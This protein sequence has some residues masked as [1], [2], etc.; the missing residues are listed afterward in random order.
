MA[1]SYSLV[2]A[3]WSYWVTECEEGLFIRGFQCAF[4]RHV[5]RMRKRRPGAIFEQHLS[6]VCMCGTASC[7]VCVS[8]VQQY[9]DTN[10][11]GVVYE[12]NSYMEQ[13]LDTGGDNKLLLYELCNIIKT[14]QAPLATHTNTCTHAHTHTSSSPI[15]ASCSIT[16]QIQP[17]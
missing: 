14:G 1:V 3:L 17:G 10:M 4:V 16:C 12:L 9:Q 6:F 5:S 7:M 8:C 13:R 11:Q 2:Q 15:A